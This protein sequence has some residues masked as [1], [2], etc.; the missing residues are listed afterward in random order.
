MHVDGGAI[1][2]VPQCVQSLRSPWLGEVLKQNVALASLH[3][4][5]CIG[6]PDYSNRLDF[7]GPATA[8][9]FPQWGQ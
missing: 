8:V 5:V 4:G 1:M 6:H 7:E 3:H 2:I 9:F